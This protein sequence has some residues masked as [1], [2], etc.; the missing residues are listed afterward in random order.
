MMMNR[1]LLRAGNFEFALQIYNPLTCQIQAESQPGQP[2][3]NYQLNVQNRMI[4]R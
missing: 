1:L 2:F 4:G 3:A